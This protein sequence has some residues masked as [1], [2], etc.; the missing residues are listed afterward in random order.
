MEHGKSDL[1]M[2]Y[3]GSTTIGEISRLGAKVLAENDIFKIGKRRAAQIFLQNLLDLKEGATDGEIETAYKACSPQPKIPDDP[4][5]FWTFV[6]VE[7]LHLESEPRE[8]F[9]QLAFQ[10]TDDLAKIYANLK[11]IRQEQKALEDKKRSV[12][13]LSAD[14][15]YYRNQLGYFENK[16]LVARDEIVGFLTDGI[17]PYAIKKASVHLSP[18]A[19]FAALGSALFDSPYAFG[20]AFLWAFHDPYDVT[21]LDDYSNKFGDLPAAIYRDLIKECRG[22]RERFKEFAFDYITG[23]PG[24]LPSVREKIEELIGKS[25]ILASRKQVIETM[26]KHFEKKDYISFVSM[27]PLQIEGIFADIC[28]GI[29]VSENELD[30]SSLNDK[31]QHIDGKI[32]SFLYFEYYSFKFP[33]LRNLVAHGGLV[34]GELEDTAVHLILD[35]LPV[36]ALTASEELPTNHALKVLDAAS[37]GQYEKLVE[38][39]DLR[40]T[41]EIPDFY[42]L[43][44]KIAATEA[45]YTSQ[46]FWDYLAGELRK[47]TDVKAIKGCGAVRA[48]GKIKSA[49]LSAKQAEE[50]LKSSDRVAREAIRQRNE[51]VESVKK[52]M[53]RRAEE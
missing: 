51:A 36:C 16:N 38:W 15:R 45:L 23:V 42:D 29:G 26:L 1:S 46:G 2:A 39:L 25:H 20:R 31:L 19:A 44:G 14:D 10:A 21:S 50:F 17:R 41:V 24:R 47:L 22:S 11:Y 28:R 8:K 30:I 32:K 18:F 34:D 12:G 9:T 43:K 4:E 52:L 5:E 27:A 49:D 33:V 37:K 40:E 13:R 6:E 35:L 53:N 7:Y 48:A 3:S